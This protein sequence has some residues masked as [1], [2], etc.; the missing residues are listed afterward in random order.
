[1]YVS[2]KFGVA[3]LTYQFNAGCHIYPGGVMN[4]RRV[5]VTVVLGCAAML[6]CSSSSTAP[7]TYP[8]SGGWYGAG[9]FGQ[10]S[11]TLSESGDS[12]LGSL[13]Y[14]QLEPSPIGQITGKVAAGS[15]SM[16]IKTIVTVPWGEHTTSQI[17]FLGTFQG[18][19]TL[20]GHGTANGLT[21]AITWVR[22]TP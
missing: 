9:A 10:Y 4:V 16:T 8:L 20:V 5:V 3:V 15:V 17:A 1:V 22:A 19:D 12:I 2:L 18:A 21:Q 6:G 7:T 14:G 13:L 11:L